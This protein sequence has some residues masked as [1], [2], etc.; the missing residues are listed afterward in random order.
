M[1]QSSFLLLLL[2]FNLLSSRI[3]KPLSA[4]DTM[5]AISPGT[6]ALFVGTVPRVVSLGCYHRSRDPCLLFLS[7]RTDLLLP[8][9]FRPHP[10]K[11]MHRFYAGAVSVAVR[12]QHRQGMDSLHHLYTT[13]WSHNF[14]S[15]ARVS[16]QLLAFKWLV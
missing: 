8:H 7:W 14:I 10:P 2:T 3:L 9:Q 15:A 5:T 16:V 1:F 11:W 4:P 12:E 13:L 6:Q